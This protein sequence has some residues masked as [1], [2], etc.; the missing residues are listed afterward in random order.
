MSDLEQALERLE[1]Y[2]VRNK[3][4]RT[5]ERRLILEKII[6]LD[7]HFT[8]NSLSKLMEGFEYVSLATIYNTLDLFLK[9]GLIVR[10]PFAAPE[11]E[12]VLRSHTHHHRICRK[13]GAIKE[14]TDLKIKKSIQNRVFTAFDID[15]TALYVY[16]LCKKCMPKKPKKTSGKH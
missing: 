3:I 5:V 10:H 6:S 2:I 14:F 16:G 8:A 7:S 12:S 9:A 1:L 11:Y 4:K 15:Y 13:C